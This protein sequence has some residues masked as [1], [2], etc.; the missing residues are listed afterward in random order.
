MG[1]EH[2]QLAD[3]IYEQ[4]ARIGKAVANPKRLELLELLSQAPRTV[5]A[6]AREARLSHANTSQHLQTLRGARLVVTTR[7]GTSVRYRLADENVADFF[8]VLRL[9]AF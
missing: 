5:D 2:R 3:G 4:I 7:E 8:R 9:L 6:L 1:D